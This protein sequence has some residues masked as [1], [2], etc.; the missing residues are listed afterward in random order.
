MDLEP[1]ITEA[2]DQPDVD[3]TTPPN[4]AAEVQ[5]KTEKV[6]GALV[7]FLSSCGIDDEAIH[8]AFVAFGVQTVEDVEE[9]IE[10]VRS[11]CTGGTISSSLP[12]RMAAYC[13]VARTT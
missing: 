11:A 6:P 13:S 2:V 1:T 3:P 4:V 7:S 12:T 9:L 10:E 8:E 5:N